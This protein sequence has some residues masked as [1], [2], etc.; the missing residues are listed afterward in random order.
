[1]TSKLKCLFCK[2]DQ[3]ERTTVDLIE[4]ID[5]GDMITDDLV[6]LHS[7]IT[8]QCDKCGKDVTDEELVRE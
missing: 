1:M 6:G 4:M 8:Y 3:F 2:H 7:K 5:N